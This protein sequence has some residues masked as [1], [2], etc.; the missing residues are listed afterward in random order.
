MEKK[1]TRAFVVHGEEEGA[2][3]W[4]RRLGDHFA[5]PHVHVPRQGESVD[6]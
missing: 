4:G 5:I 6:L 1:P 3:A 2:L